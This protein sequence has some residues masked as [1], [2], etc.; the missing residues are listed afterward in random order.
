MERRLNVRLLV[1][2]LVPSIVFG[3]VI[4]ALHHIQMDRHASVLLRQAQK[5]EMQ[6]DFVKAEEYLRLLLGYRRDDP[7]AFA[8]YGLIFA[9]RAESPNDRMQ[10]FRILEQALRLKPDQAD[11][12]QRAVD[13]A[14]SL[15][16][17][18]VAETHLKV[19]L[20]RSEPDKEGTVRPA[21]TGDGELEALLARCSAGLEDYA[22][23]ALWYKDAIG[24]APHR[25]E[26]YVHLS[27]L[28]RTRLGDMSGSDRIM[29]ARE[30]KDGLIGSNS[31]SAPAYL[32]RARYRKKYGIGGADLD[33]A[34]ALELAPNDADVLLSAAESASERGE[35]DR[36]RGH[37]GVGLECN[38]GNWRLSAASATV[39]RLMGKPHE[40]EAVLRRGIEASTD[41]D[42]RGH[43][44]W[45]LADVLIDE[46]RRPDAREVIERLTQE[47]ARPE[48]LSYLSARINI[49]EA[50]WIEAV[51]ELEAISP[52]LADKSSLAY[53][54]QLLL[55][56][57]YEQLGDIDRRHEAFQRAVSLDPS[58]T[59]GQIGLAASL[60]AMGKI[61][62]A[63]AVY[64]R[65]II[66]Q[67][68]IGP[69]VAR[70]LI[71]RNLR[72]PV[73][74]RNWDEVEQA[75]TKSAQTLPSSIE[76]IILSAEAA[77]ARGNWD[78]ARGLL[79]KAR[80]QR[81][82]QVELWIALSELAERRET[83]DVGISILKEAER[84]LGDG[85]E[86][87]LARTNHWAKRGGAEASRE[88]SAV[89]ADLAT[90][91]AIDQERLLRGLTEAQVRIGDTVAAIRLIGQ[92]VSLRPYDLSLRFS[93]FGL[94]LQVGDRAAME[95]TLAEM[96]AIEDKLDSVDRKTGAFWQCAKARFLTWSA[97]QQ[98]RGPAQKKELDEAR[99]LLAEAG[100]QRPS[101]SLVPLAEA[102]IED[103]VG[104]QD[105]A[106]KGYLRSYESGMR[107]L[108]VVRRTMQL[109]FDRRRFDQADEL[110]RKF[111]AEGV[112]SRDTQLQRLAAEVSLQVADR[113]R[114]PSSRGTPPHLSLR[115]MPTTSGWAGSFGRPVRRNRPS[116]SCGAR[117]S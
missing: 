41:R 55:G 57:C 73:E 106:V 104:N 14:L 48:L 29:D 31:R 95:T 21:A 58:A 16:L 53:Q 6:G 108:P 99:L 39:A 67:P 69:A 71:R 40:A 2:L 28:L 43:L 49:G 46:G 72:R 113:A 75:L 26:S 37:L 3:F 78:R 19:L 105:G 15:D 102:E 8:K 100:R 59:A 44:L 52:L 101:W 36:S 23:A 85:I 80:D 51:K 97:A 1:W 45:V 81:P 107:S 27:E 96:Q 103:L 74:Q 89:G 34:R 22:Q 17:F 83:M 66:Q 47:R 5:S 68:N 60:A 13:V 94:A 54:T 62:E 88:L 35:F 24:H 93:Q 86:L 87:R 32:E 90:L 82:D 20:G 64:W 56:A 7:T 84:R 4:R 42:G 111:Q 30:T 115:S 63:L 114:A 98:V 70:L 11:V 109:L 110:I 76:L 12:R 92:L 10:A 38:P 18:R 33:L 112:P 117:S 25:I 9:N 61:D 50:K 116:Q 79:L 77:A 65:T 91:S